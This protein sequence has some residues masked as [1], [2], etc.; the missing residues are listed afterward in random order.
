MK[1]TRIYI[2]NVIGVRLL[3][4]APAA[5][6]TLVAGPNGAGKSSTVESLRLALL[7]TPDRVALKKDLGAL[8]MEGEKAGK[9]VVEF[10][11]GRATMALPSGKHGTEGVI[12]QAIPALLRPELFASLDDSHR[13]SVLLSLLGVRATPDSV[14]ARLEQRGCSKSKV[15]E[16][17]PLLNSG[18]EAAAKTAA[19]RA[20]EARGA[21]KAVAGETYGSQ[22]AEGWAPAVPEPFSEDELQTERAGFD[23]AVEAISAANVRLGELRS[24]ARL[25]QEQAAQR[26]ALEEKAART[27]RIREKLER[28]QAELEQWSGRLAELPPAP[29]ATAPRPTLPCPECGAALVLNGGRLEHYEAPKADDPETATK[30]KQWQDAVDLYRRSVEHGQRDLAAAEGATEALKALGDVAAP[31][32]A[33][34]EQTEAELAKLKAQ[35]DAHNKAISELDARK[36][37]VES[38]AQRTTDAARHHADVQQWSTIAEAL[39]PDG[40][41]AQLVAD[42]LTPFN[43]KLAEYALGAQWSAPHVGADM[44]I[45]AY[46]NRPYALLSESEKWRVDALLA[47]AIAHFSGE[48]FLVLDR[49]DVL[50]PAARGDLL[51]WLSDLAEAGELQQ[52]FVFGTLKALPAELPEHFA[53]VWLERRDR[54]ADLLAA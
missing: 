35:R 46:G 53:G 41:P 44:V 25:A 26:T 49:F 12:G 39:S 7:G 4:L 51:F 43:R 31:D 50:E 13:R 30:R 29:D 37:A 20:S 34:L 19:T 21:W 24:A 11:G 23:A 18:F 22:K 36:R 1:L 45:R 42:A 48:R 33:T 38:A 27:A 52:A 47:A 10:D 9:I 17:T 54:Q 8:V 6:V 14:V 28:D 15:D 5:P 3:E 40:I 2:E 32:S 16:I